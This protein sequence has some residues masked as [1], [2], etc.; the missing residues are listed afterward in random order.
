MSSS[1][2]SLGVEGS[3]IAVRKDPRVPKRKKIIKVRWNERKM[4]NVME[5]ENQQVLEQVTSSE[6]IL[7]E[8]ALEAAEPVLAAPVRR[9]KK[10]FFFNIWKF[11]GAYLMILPAIVVTIIFAYLPM[12]GIIMA[13]KNFHPVDGI[14]GSPWAANYGFE[15]FLN[16]FRDPEM[17][18]AVKNTIVF[19]LV[20]LFGG[21]PFPIILA[22]MFNE[23]RSKWFKKVSQTIAY[24]PHFL[25]WIS[26]IGL[27]YTFLAKEGPFNQL[28]GALVQDWVPTNP[29]MKSEYFLTIMFTSHLWK[30]VGYSSVVFLAAITGIDPG[31]YEAAS[32]DGCGKWKQVWHITLPSIKPTMVII[33]VMSLGGLINVNFEQ[34]Y[35]M[36][37]AFTQLDN[38]VIGTIVYRRGIMGGDYSAT[39]AFGLFQ[40]VVSLLL[41]TIANWVSKKVT[42]QSIW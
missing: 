14:L 19:G 4:K 20:I 1:E 16:I 25:S 42:E 38:E 7:E 39:T 23:I 21:Y 18:K 9:K 17:L 37:N 40:G 33:L 11:S 32:I 13:F 31:L 34:V 15:H 10:G 26:V 28:M 29:L 5:Q 2:K 8:T 12:Y 35:G 27:L 3:K 36:Q 24:F 30:N 6:E 41:V 22:L